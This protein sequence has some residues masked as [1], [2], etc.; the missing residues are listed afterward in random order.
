MSTFSDVC[1]YTVHDNDDNDD[2]CMFK[3][4]KD[5]V[6]RQPLL[7]PNAT[8]LNLKA[9]SVSYMHFSLSKHFCAARMRVHTSSTATMF[10]ISNHVRPVNL[11]GSIYKVPIHS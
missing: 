7:Q 2:H 3:T 6:L 10:R 5:V 1:P 4:S 9:T 11:L 8:I